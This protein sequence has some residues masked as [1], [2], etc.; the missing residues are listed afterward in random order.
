M[1]MSKGY[2]NASS[3]AISPVYSKS[4]GVRVNHPLHK[5]DLVYRVNVKSHHVK[6]WPKSGT[7]LSITLLRALHCR[8][9]SNVPKT[10]F[11]T[12]QKAYPI[13]LW[14]RDERFDP[15]YP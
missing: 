6:R 11:K 5:F 3:F 10:D 14:R 8:R 1:L 15:V 12:E 9:A 2:L 13:W 7:A 4:R